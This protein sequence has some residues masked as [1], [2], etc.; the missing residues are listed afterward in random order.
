MVVEMFSYFFSFLFQK[1]TIVTIHSLSNL[2]SCFSI[3]VSQKFLHLANK[4]IV[5]SVEISKKINLKEKYILPAF[6]P[7]FMEKESKL[8]QKI[9][10]VLKQNKQ[11][12]IIVSNAFRLDFLNNEDLYGL[13]LIIDVSRM[14]KKEKRNYKIIFVVASLNEKL[15]M[16]NKIINE[17]NLSSAIY[18]VPY[19]ISFV[20]L[21]LES[22]LVIRATNT[23]GDAL[24]VREALY[25]KR[26]VIA[27]DVVR[28][29][30]GT[31]LFE[32]RNSKD[33][34]LKIKE[35]LETNYIKRLDYTDLDN[36]IR[37][38]YQN[39]YNSILES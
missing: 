35:V 25:L 19:S 14:I 24:T 18:L 31:I 28:R 9:L 33:L 39:Y 4:T 34:Y 29:P 20:K 6:V 1:K 16:Y 11:K 38:E 7:P 13:D 2:R 30:K 10:N 21:I 23:D 27:S 26:P 22:D 5:V 8:P 32:N 15:N 12:K 37:K 17:E 36:N 3:F